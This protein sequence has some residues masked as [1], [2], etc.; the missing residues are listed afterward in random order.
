VRAAQRGGQHARGS[1]FHAAGAHGWILFH[2]AARCLASVANQNS[3]HTLTLQHSPL[4]T[5]TINPGFSTLLPITPTLFTDFFASRA[6][7]ERVSCDATPGLPACVNAHSQV[8]VFKA[9]DGLKQPS[10]QPSHHPPP[11]PTPTPLPQHNHYTN[12]HPTPHPT[13]PPGRPV[14]ISHLLPIKLRSCI[15][16]RAPH[17]RRLGPPRPEALSDRRVPARAAA[18]LSR[19]RPPDGPK[20]GR[21]ASSLLP[22][23]GGFGRHIIHSGLPILLRRL[24]APAAPDCRVWAHHSGVL[25]RVCPGPAPRRAAAAGA[26]GVAHGGGD[27]G[28]RGGGGGGRARVAAASGG[29]TM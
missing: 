17:R 5:R 23:F 20:P 27:G 12:P 21:P 29:G 19:G 24:A 6:A 22:G 10:N 14:V 25:D 8:R 11:S 9:L 26:G 18:G 15:L 13:P 16:L 3:H 7:G 2:A 28:V 4:Q 1:G